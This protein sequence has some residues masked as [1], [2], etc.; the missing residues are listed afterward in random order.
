[1]T[2]ARDRYPKRVP[3]GTTL[4]S[5]ELNLPPAVKQTLIVASAAVL[6][7]A[8]SH[9]EAKQSPGNYSN[10]AVVEF[11]ELPDPAQNA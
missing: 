11:T 7:F 8:L 6:G 10:E 5:F 3:E 1:M 4:P 9:C 2:P